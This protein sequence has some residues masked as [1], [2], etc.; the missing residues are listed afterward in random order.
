MNTDDD[1]TSSLAD[2]D[3]TS[4]PGADT[5]QV[6]D[7]KESDSQQLSSAGHESETHDSSLSS[8]TVQPLKVEWKKIYLEATITLDQ[9]S[10]LHQQLQQYCGS[11]V[12]LIGKEVERIDTA[13]LQLLVTFVNHPQITVGWIDPSP[14]LCIAAQLLGL[15]S[16]LGLPRYEPT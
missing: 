16:H 9:L 13:A 3:N 6:V 7:S 8:E 2:N 10:E 14:Q 11:R 1:N 12:Q 15:S 4:S 5:I